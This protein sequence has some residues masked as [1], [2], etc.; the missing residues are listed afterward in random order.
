LSE[1][2]DKETLLQSQE[3]CGID[4]KG[5]MVKGKNESGLTINL[6]LITNLSLTTIRFCFGV[7]TLEIKQE[8]VLKVIKNALICLSK[9]CTKSLTD[10]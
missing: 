10:C 1:V 5:M 9:I 3:R 2:V 4:S 6:G 7:V 8:P